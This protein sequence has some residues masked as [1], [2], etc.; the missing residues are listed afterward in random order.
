MSLQLLVPFVL[1]MFPIVERYA[2]SV[3]L[4]ENHM[5]ILPAYLLVLTGNMLPVVFIVY[6]LEPVTDFC[7]KYS[8]LFKKVFEAVCKYSRNKNAEKFEKLKELAILLI[9]ALPIPLMGTWSGALA[10]FL[11]GVPPKKS[12][13][14]IFIGAIISNTFVVLA[15]MGVMAIGF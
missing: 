7:S 13:P 4:V 1:A 6:F 3:A 10:A 2:I 12:L 9:A 8:K 5:A 15:T 14:L 11:F